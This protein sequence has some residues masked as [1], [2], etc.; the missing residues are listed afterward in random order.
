[1]G[2][3]YER[4]YSMSQGEKMPLTHNPLYLD[5]L[6]KKVSNQMEFTALKE[7]QDLYPEEDYYPLFKE[8]I[9]QRIEINGKLAC[10]SR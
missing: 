8:N 3:S 7:L 4:G 5:L 2:F 9:D 10:F 6:R 1:M